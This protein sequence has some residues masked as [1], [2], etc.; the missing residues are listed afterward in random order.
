MR[1]T[2]FERALEQ[3]TWKN[4]EGHF[5]EFDYFLKNFV[6]P[7]QAPDNYSVDAAID[8]LFWLDYSDRG[9]SVEQIVTGINGVLVRKGLSKF[10]TSVEI[11][12]VKQSI[13]NRTK[14][15]RHAEAYNSSRDRRAFNLRFLKEWV[16]H[17]G[18]RAG[19]RTGEFK[20]VRDAAL[21]AVAFRLLRRAV[22]VSRWE[23]KH[24]RFVNLDVQDKNEARAGVEFFLGYDKTH[25]NPIYMLIEEPG[26][27][28]DS[29]C[30]PYTLFREYY[31]KFVVHSAEDSPLFPTAHSGK[32]MN[33]SSITQA[34][35]NMVKFAGETDEESLY[36][37][38]HSLR[39]GGATAMMQNGFSM[40]QIR[41]IGGWK[42]DVILQYLRGRNLAF[43][44]LSQ[45]MGF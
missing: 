44:D 23:K 21:V 36:Y 32:P 11:K 31:E 14:K 43:N 18:R 10:P 19:F 40:A 35:R 13:V 41:S 24:V 16:K 9:K 22:D 45:N 39:I 2:F 26:K 33:A 30:H 25:D 15:K 1:E 38:A 17:G 27:G 7:P 3:K 20:A 34:I 28:S 5:A 8:F 42:S 6:S 12:K 29:S 4:Y 37:S